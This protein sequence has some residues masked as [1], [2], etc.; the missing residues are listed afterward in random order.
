MAS[1]ARSGTGE[2]LLMVKVS[3]LIGAVVAPALFMGMT[4]MSH[5]LK[6]PGLVASGD[7]QQMYHWNM[8]PIA[9]WPDDR[10]V[11]LARRSELRSVSMAL[12]SSFP[13]P[14]YYHWHPGFQ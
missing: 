13:H 9:A 4:A 8:W 14:S 6:L 2:S 10:T 7:M 12:K 5:F 1:N 11:A 3:M